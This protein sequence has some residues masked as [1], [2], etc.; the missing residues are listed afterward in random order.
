MPVIVTWNT[1]TRDVSCI[2]EDAAIYGNVINGMY[3]FH[4][5]LFGRLL[6][7][8]GPQTTVILLSDHGFYHDHLR[9]KVHEHFRATQKIRAE[10]ESR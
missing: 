1:S 6:E 3:R 2:W 9:P 8:V 4:D 7:L 10:Y 5:I